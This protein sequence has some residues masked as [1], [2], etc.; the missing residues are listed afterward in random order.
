MS[1]QMMSD[2]AST[3]LVDELAWE[4]SVYRDEERKSLAYM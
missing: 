1:P 4:E 3:V 2:T